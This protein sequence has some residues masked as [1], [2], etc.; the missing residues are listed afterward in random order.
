MRMGEIPPELRIMYEKMKE[1][2]R[3]YEVYYA[4][5]NIEGALDNFDELL[6]MVKWKPP[7]VQ[8]RFY[9][10]ARQMLDNLINQFQKELGIE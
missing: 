2:Q 7:L 1:T 3:K 4:L 10:A 9:R 6:K 8:D 5:I